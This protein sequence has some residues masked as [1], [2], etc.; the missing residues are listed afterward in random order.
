MTSPGDKKRE[1]VWEKLA[2]VD[3][4]APRCDIVKKMR[5]AG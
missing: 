2:P 1:R 5:G 4:H 3:I